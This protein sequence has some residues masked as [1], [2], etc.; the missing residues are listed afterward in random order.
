M[1]TNITKVFT[2]LQ[3]IKDYFDNDTYISQSMLKG[4]NKDTKSTAMA[5]GS[6]VDACCTMTEEDFNSMYYVSDLPPLEPMMQKLVDWYMEN[7]N[8]DI[9]YDVQIAEYMVDNNMQPNWKWDTRLANVSKLT[10]NIQERFASI[11]RTVVTS[12]QVSHANHIASLVN[13]ELMSLVSRLVGFDDCSI[14]YQQ[15]QYVQH[16]GY[17]LKCLPDVMIE[18]NNRIYIIDIKNTGNVNQ[19]AHTALELR[20]D[21]QMAYY[22]FIM[23]C[24]EYYVKDCYWLACDDKICNSYLAHPTDLMVGQ[25]GYTQANTAYI[26]GEPVLTE[27]NKKGFMQL[28]HDYNN[29]QTNKPFRIHYG[30]K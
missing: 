28:L 15:P 7:N 10:P 19:F 23:E 1:M 13:T 20:Y 11:G 9:A 3:A 21:I 2:P 4:R 24:K 5:Q 26:N 14:V 16:Q 22:K 17:C 30:I 6:L 18:H 29:K 12:K 27:Y 8:M 25:Y